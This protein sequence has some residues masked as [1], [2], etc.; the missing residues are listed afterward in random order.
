MVGHSIVIA[1]SKLINSIYLTGKWLE[2]NVSSVFFT[3][4][5]C[6]DQMI[7]CEW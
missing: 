5:I 3:V 7:F 6:K 1:G 2:L 4:L